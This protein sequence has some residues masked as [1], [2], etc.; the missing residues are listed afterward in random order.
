[1]S[2]LL[3]RSSLVGF[4]AAGALHAQPITPQFRVNS[5]TLYSQAFP[6]IA[7]QSNKGYV[8]VWATLGTTLFGIFGQRLSITGVPVGAEFQLDT[9]TGYKT[10]PAVASDDTGAFVVVWSGSKAQGNAGIFGRRYSVIG[11]PLGD[12]FRVNPI[13]THD[14]KFPSVAVDP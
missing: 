3:A 5:T 13:T 12:D 4:L 2:G 11:V 14:T 6:S 8:V 10:H 1:M 7:R 9:S